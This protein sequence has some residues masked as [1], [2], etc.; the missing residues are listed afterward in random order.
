MTRGRQRRNT[1]AA[2]AL[3]LEPDATACALAP[4]R[5]AGRAYLTARRSLS[6]WG[7]G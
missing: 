2:G 4:P 1:G 5:L 3:E 6:A 7:G